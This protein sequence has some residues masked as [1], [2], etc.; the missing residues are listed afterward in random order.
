MRNSIELNL[1]VA[2]VNA[3]LTKALTDHILKANGYEVKE[4]FWDSS[5]MHFRIKL[6][7]APAV[8]ITYVNPNAASYLSNTTLTCPPTIR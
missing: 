6:E 5:A 4:V 2:D 7:P 8:N 1:C 3:L